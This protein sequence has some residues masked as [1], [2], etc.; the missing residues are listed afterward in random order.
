MPLT[1]EVTLLNSNVTT[2]RS[3]GGSIPAKWK[4][5]HGIIFT[6][7][8]LVFFIAGVTALPAY[9]T[10]AST[11]T[12]SITASILFFWST[13]LD[14]WK[15]SRSISN[16]LSYSLPV[17]SS[18]GLIVG[19]VILAFPGT[20]VSNQ[21]INFGCT[22]I[23]C[24]GIVLTLASGIKIWKHEAVFDSRLHYYVEV[25]IAFAGFGFAFYGILRY[26]NIDVS[27]SYT[28]AAAAWY[29]IAGLALSL[30]ALILDIRYVSSTE[31]ILL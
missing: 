15:R 20:Y 17:L 28:E 14:W 18:F 21:A 2:T 10:Y 23:L 4:W 5:Y 31:Y 13:F 11:G 29:I 6:L 26:P 25:F 1:E 7:S 24:A 27:D 16:G 30:S 22:C 19:S 8:A 9:T 3:I 12:L